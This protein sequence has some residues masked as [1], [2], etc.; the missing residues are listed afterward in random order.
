MELQNGAANN[1]QWRA[2][3]H[4]ALFHCYFFIFYSYFIFSILFSL[5]HLDTLP[6]DQKKKVFPTAP[7]TPQDITN[8]DQHMAPTT[9]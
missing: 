2:S 8:W 4:R 3:E 6:L 1:E 7:A 5:E 9:S